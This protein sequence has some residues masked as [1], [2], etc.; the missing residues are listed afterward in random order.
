LRKGI[1][2]MRAKWR[3]A[4]AGAS[5]FAGKALQS[6]PLQPAHKGVKNARND[7]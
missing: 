2:P 7:A 4:R 1:E 5:L 6:V 3:G